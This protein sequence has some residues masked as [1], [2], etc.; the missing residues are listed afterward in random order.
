MRLQKFSLLFFFTIL[1]LSG[2]TFAQIIT[3]NPEFPTP[4]DSVIITFDATEGNQEL[5]DYSGDVYAHT[6]IT[7]NGQQWQKVIADWTQNIDKAKLTRVSENIYELAITPSIIDYYDA[8]ENNDITELCFVFRSSD[9]NKQTQDLFYDVYESGVQISINTPSQ[10]RF[11]A[12][13]GETFTFEASASEGDSI[14]L[15]ADDEL[16]YTVDTTSISK[17]LSFNEQ[18]AKWLWVKAYSDTATNADSLRAFIRSD[19][20]IAELP[21]GV[22][23]GIN[24]IDD[25]IVTLV[26]HAPEKDFAFAIGDFSN[27]DLDSAYY[28][29]YTPD[30]THFWVTLDGINSGQKYRYQYFV[31]GEI[32]IADPYTEKILDPWNDQY[33]SSDTYPNLIGYPADKAEGIVSVFETAQEEYEWQVTDFQPPVKED[34]VIYELLIRDFTADGQVG[35]IQGV[36]NKL[37]YLDSLGV[38]AIELMPVNEFEGND[39]WGYN[40]SFYFAFDK[41]YGQKQDMKAFVDS[42]HKRGIAVIVD[43]VLNHSYGQSPFV[44]LY[45]DP[46]AGDYGQPTAANPWYNQTCPHPPYCWGFDFDHQAEATKNLVDSINTFWLEEYNI[47]GFRFDFTKGLTNNSSSDEGWSYDQQRIDNLKRMADEIWKTNPEAYV[48]LEHF[49]ENSEEKELSNYGMMTWGNLNYAYNQATMGK[50][51][52]NNSDFSWVSYNERGWDK[53]HL[54]GYME[55]HDEERLMYNNLEDGNIGTGYDITELSNALDRIELAANFFIPVPGPKMIW[56]F[57]ELGYDYSINYN[58][59]LG[60]KP[61]KWEYYDQEDRRDVYNVFSALSRLKQQEPAFSS[62]NF[63]FRNSSGAVK[64]LVIEHSD[65]DVYIIGN[66]GVNQKTMTPEFTQSGNWYELYTSDSIN[67]SNVDDFTLDAGEYRLYTTKKLNISGVGDD[68]DDATTTIQSFAG[69]GQIDVFPNP[70]RDVVTFEFESSGHSE[71]LLNIYNTTGQKVA[72]VKKATLSSEKN[73]IKWTEEVD[74]AAEPKM[75]FY[76]LLLDDERFTGKFLKY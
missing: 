42:C 27:W 75:Y 9:G 30:S 70:A 8:S 59:R 46:D 65:M 52:D 39:S 64:E 74:N 51:S 69:Q 36:M 25:T 49:T 3:A 37:D 15:Y 2:N 13:Q 32:M 60:K 19:V 76:E 50:N 5:M 71:I 31:D 48:I 26:L 22:S 58:G 17:N 41:A 11:V 73:R 7:I 24:Y 66:F 61:V 45:F 21:Q 62:S 67:T 14:E 33:I 12:K 57:G 4:N 29:N 34:L 44:Q 6:G 72:S 23:N 16:L 56:Q 68:G 38:N 20:N 40:P 18:G 43:M 35:D 55:S 63:F 28:M 54:V 53:P 10:E 47:D 1:L